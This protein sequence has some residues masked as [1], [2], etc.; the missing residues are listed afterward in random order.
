MPAWLPSRPRVYRA[1]RCWFYPL[2]IFTQFPALR[3]LSILSCELLLSPPLDT[4]NSLSRWVIFLL[5]VLSVASR[6]SKAPNR[7]SII[8]QAAGGRQSILLLLLSSTQ[9]AWWFARP[10]CNQKVTGLIPNSQCVHQQSC[11]LLE[12]PWQWHCS[13]IYWRRVNCFKVH[14]D[15]ELLQMRMLSVSLRSI[16]VWEVLKY[17]W[18]TYMR[19]F[20]RPLEII[21]RLISEL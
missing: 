3:P 12:C 9:A 7:C 6:T 5:W 16:D 2:Q 20:H 19:G 18:Y 4:R 17:N 14:M 8:I 21:I 11:A 15:R 13:L 1:P 10:P